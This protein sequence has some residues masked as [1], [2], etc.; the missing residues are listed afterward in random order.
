MTD[1]PTLLTI[2]STGLVAFGIVSTALLRGWS[3][4]LAVRRLEIESSGRKDPSVAGSTR[5]EVASLRERV[6][7][8]EAIANGV[9]S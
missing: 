7:R 9:D 2:A 3:G 5:T 6:R 1:A 4:W 8:L